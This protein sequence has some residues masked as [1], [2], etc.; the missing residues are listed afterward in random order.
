M[1]QKRVLA[2][3]RSLGGDLLEELQAA[4]ERL[5]EALL[6]GPDDLLDP[7]AVL[8]ELRVPRAHLL[9]D[10]L[11][12]AP[13]VVEADRPRLLNGAADDPAQDVAAPFVRREDAVADQERHPAPVVGQD[14][15]RLRRLL[16]LAERDAALRGDPVHDRLVAVRLV[17]RDDSL[18]DARRA[19]EAHAGVDVLL[20][21][22]RD[23]A[24]GVQLELHEDEVP[25]L[26]VPLAGAARRA[27][28][29]PAAKRLA[30]VVEELGVRPARPGA[31]DRPEVVGAVEADDALG[32][33]PDLLPEPYR[34]LVLAE[35]ELRVTREDRDPEEVRVDLHVVEDELPG[36]LDRAFL[37]VLPEREVAEHLEEREVE[38]VE[39][40]LVDVRGS[41]DLL[42]RCQERRR[43]LL[44]VPGSTA[45]AAACRRCSGASNGPRRAG[46]ASRTGAACGPSTRSTRGIPRGALRWCA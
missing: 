22:R 45:S 14:P 18:E 17:D 29:S 15:M 9:C 4:L 34:L 19:L 8:D 23:R 2:R 32:R 16:R 10:H 21:E 11:G 26:E 3:D 6:L 28:R 1:E 40:D 31:A 7:F 38:A 44:R 37:E 5:G 33:H 12:D 27:L 46:R 41:E 20:R 43:R 35:P 30:A 36:E 24:V 13:E 42:R 25:E 39:A